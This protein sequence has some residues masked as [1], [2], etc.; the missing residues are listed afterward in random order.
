MNCRILILSLYLDV[1]R[2]ILVSLIFPVKNLNILYVD[3][4]DIV[5]YKVQNRDLTEWIKSRI[6]HLEDTLAKNEIPE[7]EVSGLCKFCRY[8]TRCFADGDG[9]INKPLSIPKKS[10]T[11]EIFP[12]VNFS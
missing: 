8:Q 1:K 3:M 7:G 2:S 11:E 9:L 5:A 12:V 10:N 4:N 6:Q